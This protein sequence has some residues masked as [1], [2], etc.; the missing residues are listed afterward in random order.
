[1]CQVVLYVLE[2]SVVGKKCP[3][4]DGMGVVERESK[5]DNDQVK[6]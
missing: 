4:S 1:M 3:C 5:E 2:N 6:T